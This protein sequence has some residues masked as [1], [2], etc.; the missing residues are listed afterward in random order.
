VLRNHWV[1]YV[2]ER[3]PTGPMPSLL[4]FAALLLF[5]VLVAPFV[6][7]QEVVPGYEVFV[8]PTYVR[9]DINDARIVNGKF[10]SRFINA[11]GWHASLTGNAN[12]WVGAVF[13]FSGE[14]SNPRFA[15]SDFELTG[16]PQIHVTV[17]TSSY[18]YLFGP[19]F[20]Y[21]RM[22]HVT[23]FVEGLVG[24]ATFRF[25]SSDLGVTKPISTTGFAGAFGGG[26]DLPIKRWFTIRA[27]HV[28][29]IITRFQELGPDSTGT[30]VEFNGMRRTQNNVR[31]S[32]GAIFNFGHSS[33]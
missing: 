15:P 7:A 33:R 24:V 11:V 4:K 6:H 26:I 20:T 10:E 30:T 16:L 29:Y 9:E 23:P 12:S 25:T 8:G 31:A 22:Q 13:D 5:V 28:D 21:R 3:R 2:C 18:T 1:V 19:R 32:V 14:F 17:N 27:A